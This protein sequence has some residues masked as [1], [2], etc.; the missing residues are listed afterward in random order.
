M[1]V[2]LRSPV[3]P[4]NRC[5]GK[6]FGLTAYDRKNRIAAAFHF[7]VAHRSVGARHQKKIFRNLNRSRSSGRTAAQPLVPRVPAR[8]TRFRLSK[9]GPEA[10]WS[11]H[12]LRPQKSTC[13]VSNFTS[14][15][16]LWGAR[17]QK[18]IF[19]KLNKSRSIGAT[20]AQPP[21]RGF[22]RAAAK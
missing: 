9:R 22:P 4:F 13:G 6:P 8:R 2:L 15:T 3:E 12:S 20:A 1:G 11:L 19:R 10:L 16:G 14:H 17:H 5:S 21:S 18:K 7:Y